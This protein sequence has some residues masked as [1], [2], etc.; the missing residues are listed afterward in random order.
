M[1]G[2]P[3][4]TTFSWY[5]EKNFMIIYDRSDSTYSTRWI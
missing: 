3:E 4:N 5:K 2:S 1:S